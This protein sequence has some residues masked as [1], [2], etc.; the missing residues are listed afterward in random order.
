[1]TGAISNGQNFS[2]SRTTSSRSGLVFPCG[3]I[4][5]YL[6]KSYP[7]Y[8]I[9]VGTRV[10]LAAVLEYITAEILELAGNNA[11]DSKKSR[12]I[13]NHIRNALKVD[14]EFSKFFGDAVLSDAGGV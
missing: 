1:M 11:K 14:P 6:K 8:R 7:T 9:S 4:G 3:R 12:I 2:K 10:Y 5:R 13:P